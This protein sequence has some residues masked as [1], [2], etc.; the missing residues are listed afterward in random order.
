MSYKSEN[1]DLNLHVKLCAERY[2]GI[3]D[4][5]ERLENKVDSIQKEILEGSKSLKTVIITSATT[6]VGSMLAIIIT[7][8]MKF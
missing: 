2:Q 4:R 1:E 3:Q 7:V 8:L 5:F 6:I